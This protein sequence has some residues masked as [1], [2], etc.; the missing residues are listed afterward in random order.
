LNVDFAFNEEQEQLRAAVREYLQREAPV[1]FARS[2]MDDARGFTDA[3]WR[4]IAGLGWTG[5]TVAEEHGGSA[6]RIL[7]LVIVAEEMGRVVFPG[8]YLSAVAMGIE[9]ISSIATENQK[10]VHLPGLASGQHRATLAVAEETGQWLASGIAL[11]ARE[12]A[13]GY[14]LSGTKLFV[15]DARS[16]DLIV[17]VAR[18]GEALGFFAVPAEARGLTIE[19]MTTVDATRKLDV[20]ALDRV[21]VARDALLGEK[22]AEP[23]ALDAIVDRVKV[24]LA[25]E[26]CG[27][28][29]AALDMSVEYA[30]IRKQFDR[31]IGTFQAIQHKLADMKVLLENARSLVY[32]AAWAL[33]E[34]AP[35]ARLAAAMA[36]AYASDSCL[37]VAAD[38]IQAHGGIG[39]TWEHDLHLYF[40]RIEADALTF[41]DATL[42]R[43][44]VADLLQ[45]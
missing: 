22:T 45:L 25:A 7:D 23:A 39:F 14:E 38:A 1:S 11:S 20:V 9:A 33:D 15:P 12:T 26:M 19:P 2:M 8:P 31:P 3:S 30:K 40:K 21:P 17:V 44:I 43:E 13:N 32:Y 10:R 29:A 4:A 41:G 18:L 6:L 34:R 27:G 24:V 28:A 16:A 37:R 42:N 5:L 36:K 35:D